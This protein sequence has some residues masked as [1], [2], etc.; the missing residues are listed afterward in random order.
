MSCCGA[1]RF[2]PWERVHWRIRRDTGAGY[3]SLRRLDHGYSSAIHGYRYVD[4]GV[5][6]LRFPGKTPGIFVF[7]IA[8]GLLALASPSQPV[9]HAALFALSFLR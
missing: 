3:G 5:L 1:P 8:A 7:S 9:I 2:L 6:L 4:G